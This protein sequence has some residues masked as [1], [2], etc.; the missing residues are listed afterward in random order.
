MKVATT[1][2]ALLLLASNVRAA[3]REGKY[4]SDEEYKRL[5]HFTAPS[6]FYPDGNSGQ[7]MLLIICVDRGDAAVLDRLLNAVPN[8]A[9]VVEHG[10]RCSPA[11]WAAFKGNTNLLGV[12]R[13]HGADLKKEGTN[14]RISPLHIARDPDTVDFLLDHGVDIESTAVHVQTPLMWA[15]RCGNLEVA[16]H[17]IKR[18]AKLNSKDEGGKTALALAR[19]FGHTNLVA[20]LVGKGA[21]APADQKKETGFYDV[22]VGNFSGAGAEHP[23]AESTLIYGSPTKFKR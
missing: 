6:N 17:L 13:K 1:V 12:L 16:S 15:A 2:L 5:Q 10:S 23:F 22:T 3:E 11:H 20:F 7:L 8:F 14:W 19:T 18:G 21:V 4:Y 9:N